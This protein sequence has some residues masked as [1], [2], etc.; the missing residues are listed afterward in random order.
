MKIRLVLEEELR[1]GASPLDAARVAVAK[2]RR[3]DL[4]G[5]VTPIIE[6]LARNIARNLTGRRERHL[7]FPLDLVSTPDALVELAEDCFWVDGRMVPWLEATA[8]DHLSRAAAQRRLAAGVIADAELHEHAAHEIEA[9]GV[10]CLAELAG[11]TFLAK[12]T[13]A[14]RRPKTPRRQLANDNQAGR[15]AGSDRVAA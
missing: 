9:A 5:L 15:A 10:G 13:V 14:P 7:V 1:G 2:A 11:A 6:D 3:R 4:V 12:T 8:A